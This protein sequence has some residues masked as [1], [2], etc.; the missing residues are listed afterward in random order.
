M[1]SLEPETDGVSMPQFNRQIAKFNTL[2]KLTH[3]RYGTI[4]TPD[5]PT[6]ALDVMT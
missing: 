4:N 3:A 2:A 5:I 1:S 6:S